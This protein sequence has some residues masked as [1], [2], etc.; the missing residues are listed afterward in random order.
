M[1]ANPEQSA[2]SVA[3][4]LFDEPYAFE[5]AQA[6]RLL[7]L[8][9]P[10]S[11]P[12]GTGLDPR[13]EALTLSGAL[14]P[15]FAPSAL[16][17][18]RRA[19]PRALAVTTD[20][21]DDRAPQPELE[22]NAFGLGGPEG[23]LPDA[24]QE[25]LQDRLRQKDTSAVA[26]LNLFQHRLLALLYRAQ[27]KYRIAD[28][29]L[30]PL[31]SP[32]QTILR[33]LTGLPLPK[34]GA[35]TPAGG[36]HVSAIL[37]R[38]GL[39]ANRRRSL[40]G[41]DVIAHHHFGLPVRSSPFAGGWRTLPEESQTRIGR[42]G[43][44]HLLGQG[45]VVGTRIWDEHR[46]IRIEIGP[47][48]LASYQ[49]FLPGGRC[50]ADLHALAA[51]YFGTDLYQHLDLHLAAGQQPKAQLSRQAPLRLGWTAWVGASDTPPARTTHTR[52]G[53]RHPGERSGAAG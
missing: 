45:T 22:V 7:E 43:C 32:A 53:A 5:F 2:R 47:L 52:L 8:L 30:A 19:P 31:H 23:P 37:A 15:A 11:V 41:F 10:G 14:A 21:T 9:R 6:V 12:L 38:A 27:R 18:L 25:W 29:F 35:A 49:S 1:A 24:Y 3:Q 16:G 20:T 50:H 40:A 26:F 34:R 17:A 36:L 42:R 44:N 46:G 13:A 51:A 28:P 39:M 33:G 48:P 4:R